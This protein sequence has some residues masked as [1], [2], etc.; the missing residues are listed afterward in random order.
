[1]LLL[2]TIT[3]F[4]IFFLTGIRLRRRGTLVMIPSCLFFLDVRV[5]AVLHEERERERDSVTIRGSDMVGAKT[6]F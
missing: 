4:N 5:W 6:L 3:G 1:M 2:L